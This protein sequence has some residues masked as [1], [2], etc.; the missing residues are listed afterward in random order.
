MI[1]TKT[2]KIQRYFVTSKLQTRLIASIKTRFKGT[3]NLQPKKKR[4]K[5]KFSNSIFFISKQH[6]GEHE[7]NSKMYKTT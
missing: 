3:E 2:N 1:T 4:K 5:T 7:Y 6:N